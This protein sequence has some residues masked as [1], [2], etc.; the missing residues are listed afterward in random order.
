MWSIKI[1]K[2]VVKEDFKKVSSKQQQDILRTIYKKLSIDPE[3][4]G[5]PLRTNLK[6]YW[7]LRISDYR[8]V[9]QIKKKEVL[10]FVLKIGMR[11]NKKV[12]RDMIK[13]MNK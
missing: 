8:I 5:T 10:V 9:Y 6:G 13:R 4:F 1:H 2:D 3:K 11:R 7:K 12:Y